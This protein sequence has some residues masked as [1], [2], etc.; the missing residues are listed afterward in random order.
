MAHE[1]SVMEKPWDGR[2]YF[3]HGVVDR[4]VFFHSTSDATV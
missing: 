3:E 4:G 2:E 1:R